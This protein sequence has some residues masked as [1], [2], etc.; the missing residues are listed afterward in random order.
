[1]NHSLSDGPGVSGV[2]LDSY[3]FLPA[4]EGCDVELGGEPHHKAIV[5][6]PVLVVFGQ[7]ELG[8]C[9]VPVD[10]GGIRVKALEMEL[11]DTADS[12][13]V[14][15]GSELL[16]VMGIRGCEVDESGLL[17]FFCFGHKVLLI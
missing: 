10:D 12:P 1:M 4:R 5:G 11:S 3:G 16:G 2:R 13:H 7:S 9:L 8:G 14:A 15:K 6:F 17:E